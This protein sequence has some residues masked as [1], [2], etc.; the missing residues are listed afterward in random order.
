MLSV[1]PLLVGQTMYF[2]FQIWF[3]IKGLCLSNHSHISPNVVFPYFPRKKVQASTPIGFNLKSVK[4]NRDE[5]F[6]EH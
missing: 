4:E 2:S 6:Y 1:P 5:E 3:L